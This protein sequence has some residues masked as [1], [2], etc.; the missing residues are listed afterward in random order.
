MSKNRCTSVDWLADFPGAPPPPPTQEGFL[1]EHRSCF[2]CSLLE[3]LE[4]V[5]L[6]GNPLSEEL[7]VVLHY[8]LASLC[9]RLQYIDV[10]G[11]LT[12]VS[13]KQ[14]EQSQALLS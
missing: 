12:A 13:L 4:R 3:E 9:P 7:K 2:F 5:R 8:H 1:C 6:A 11:A 10:S 14:R